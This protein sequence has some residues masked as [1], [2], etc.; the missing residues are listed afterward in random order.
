MFSGATRPVVTP[1]AMN[2]RGRWSAACIQVVTTLART[3]PMR[4]WRR[5]SAKPVQAASSHQLMSANAMTAPRTALR[6]MDGSDDQR[7]HRRGAGEDERHGERRSGQGDEGDDVPAR[8]DAEPEHAAA[9]LADAGC[10][11]RRG[12]W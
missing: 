10:G 4:P 2:T 6:A 12:P 5:W 3:G 11:R 8:A 1:S 9:E 7:D